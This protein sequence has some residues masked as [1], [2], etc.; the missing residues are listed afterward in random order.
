V[1]WLAYGASNC[2][3]IFSKTQLKK[4]AWRRT[5]AAGGDECRRIA[6]YQRLAS[7]QHGGKRHGFY[8]TLGA[9]C[10]SIAHNASPAQHNISAAS[11]AAS[12][13][14]SSGMVSRA[15]GRIMRI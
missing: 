13:R 5:F 9:S 6:R 3:A 15:G 11:L 4:W 1:A 10:R 2:I 14:V 7:Q 8:R 12:S